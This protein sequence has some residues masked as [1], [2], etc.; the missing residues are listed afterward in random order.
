MAEGSGG[1]LEFEALTERII[2]AAIKVQRAL[3]NGLLES[4][5]EACLAY[6]LSE[7]G[8]PFQ[9]QVPLEIRYQSLVIPNAYRMDMV[10]NNLVVV[11]LKTVEKLL[12]VHEA[13]VMTYLKFTGK[14]LGL[15]LNFW[16]WPLKE[17][18]IKRVLNPDVPPLPSIFSPLPS[19]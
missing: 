5:Y 3:G 7:A 10:V 6:E 12:P 8:I 9:A 1:G 13:Q 19:A 14:R 15:I 2:G 16:A 4:A 11:E 18:G 17:G